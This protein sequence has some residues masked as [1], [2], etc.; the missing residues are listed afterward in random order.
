MHIGRWSSHVGG[1]HHAPCMQ[2]TDRHKVP[3]YLGIN[4]CPTLQKRRVRTC[5]FKRGPETRK[6]SRDYVRSSV[7]EP[8][9]LPPHLQPHAKHVVCLPSRMECILKY[10]A[11]TVFFAEGE[12]VQTLPI[13]FKR[14]AKA[15]RS[16][17][18]LET[19]SGSTESMASADYR[20]H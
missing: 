17:S 19:Y 16:C 13:E 2:A 15:P 12:A 10:T 6:L 4:A 5:R 11:H 7:F 18:S 1:T 9:Q 8:A 3:Y 14:A 20:M